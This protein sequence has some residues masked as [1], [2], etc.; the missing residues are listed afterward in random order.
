MLSDSIS[1]PRAKF[2][3][4]YI[5]FEVIG[6]GLINNFEY[7]KYKTQVLETLNFKLL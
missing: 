3:R 5:F 6:F 2:R 7:C 4:N 1:S